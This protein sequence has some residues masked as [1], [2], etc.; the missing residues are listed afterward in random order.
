MIGSKKGHT[1]IRIYDSVRLRGEMGRL[2][3][4]TSVYRC[5][6]NQATNQKLLHLYQA[7]SAVPSYLFDD[8]QQLIVRSIPNISLLKCEFHMLDSFLHC[9]WTTDQLATGFMN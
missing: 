9:W 3:V 5:E 6:S 4:D 1:G 8:K 7:A 2:P